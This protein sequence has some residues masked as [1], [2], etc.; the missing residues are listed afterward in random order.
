MF[1]DRQQQIVDLIT[2]DGEIKIAELKDRFAVTEMTIRR[3]LEKL[4]QRG[5]VRRTFGGAISVGKDVSLSERAGTHVEE[6]KRIGKVAAALIQPG[7]SIFIDGGST[8][9][10]IARHLPTG[11]PFTVVTNALN[12]ASELIEKK[13]PV[14]VIGGIVR[15]STLSMSGPMAI[16]AISKMAFDR[17]FLGASGLNKRDGFG[18]SNMFEAELKRVAITRSAETSIVLDHSKFGTNS[19]VSFTEIGHVRRMI[20]DRLPEEDLLMALREAGVD[21]MTGEH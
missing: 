13:I 2:T 12:V 18:N 6:K 14:I 3:D 10:Q 11:A 19:L 1:N 7:E 9:L 20:T 4:E 15:D 8:T 17:A 5:I 21:I 16:E